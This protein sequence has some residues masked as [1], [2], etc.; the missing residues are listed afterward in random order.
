M[1]RGQTLL[2]DADD[3]LWENNIYFEE[4]I[5]SFCEL[6]EARGRT[7]EAAR[8]TLTAIERERTKS[9]GYGI[10]N[11]QTS[12]TH[13]CA[14]LLGPADHLAELDLLRELC[15]ALWRRPVT[16]LP[17]VPETLAELSGRHRLIL[18]TKGDLDDQQLKLQRSGLRSLFHQ[19]D[20]VREK[21]VRAYQDAIARHGIRHA[22]GWM[23]GNSPRSDVVPALE[24]G[25]GVVFI[26]HHATWELEHDEVPGSHD[27]RLLVLERFDE[28]T[29]HF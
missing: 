12:L 7:R 25:L 4:V 28:L 9:S 15:A 11:F 24:S 27:G 5:Q 13:A 1:R 17:G 23:I 3:T 14:E 16:L 21:D 20:V 8:R 19:V 2:I 18:F 26:P 10:R 29:N 6:I 22:A